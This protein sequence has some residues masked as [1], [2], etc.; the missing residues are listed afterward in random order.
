MKSA[1]SDGGGDQGAEEAFM[2]RMPRENRFPSVLEAVSR[3][4]ERLSYQHT[5]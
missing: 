1:V 4:I 5:V 2:G 3:V